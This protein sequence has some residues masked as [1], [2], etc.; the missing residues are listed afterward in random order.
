LQILSHKTLP[1]TQEYLKELLQTKKFSSPIAVTCDIQTQGIGSRD[2]KWDGLEGNLFVS[3]SLSLETLPKDLKI[4]SASIY[5]AYILKVT[6]EELGSKVWLKWPN[7][8]YIDSFKIGGMI[9]NI[10][11]KDI[12]CGFGLNLVKAPNGF[13]ML[14]IKL[15]KTFFLKKYF[16]NLEKRVLWKQVFSNYKLEFE[17]SKSFFT[18]VK[19]KK[20]N[21]NEATL[22]NDGSL[23]INGERMYSLR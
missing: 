22:Q 3:F 7:D 15:E 5:F 1:S 17:R 18:H 23:S 20:I 11:G 13:S 19:N 16:E 6:L 10:I 9:T 14:D 21:L 2:N 8:F 12:I 4:E